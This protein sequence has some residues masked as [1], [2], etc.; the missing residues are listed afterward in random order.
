MTKRRGG[1]ARPTDHGEGLFPLATPGEKD[2]GPYGER[3]GDDAPASR[4]I[5]LHTHILPG[6]DHGSAD[7]D[8]T[9][10]MARIAAADGIAVLAVTPHVNFEFPNAPGVIR[11][12][13]SEFRERLAAVGVPLDARVG[14]DYHLTPELLAQAD[15]IITLGDNG[16]Y[17]LLEFPATV[18]PPN[19]LDILRRFIERGLRPVIT[20]P[21]RNPHLA[22]RPKLLEEMVK[23]GCLIQVTAGSLTGLFGPPTRKAA[24][25]I[26]R[27]GLCHL[28]ASDAHW[29]T[30][31]SPL[32]SPALFVMRELIGP[33]A[34]ERI[35]FANPQRVLRGEPL[36]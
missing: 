19:A 7:W 16:C 23:A 18:V 27:A 21:E 29:A 22:A 35:M 9:M 12:A 30:E 5:D 14:G 34:A 25:T 2:A 1:A 3:D 6:L 26:L 13:T 36:V 17:F 32:L 8:E 28:V 10:A 24:E 31:R 15:G 20:H 4:L 33:A 11:E